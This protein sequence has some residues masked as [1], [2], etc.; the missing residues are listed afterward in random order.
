MTEETSA[1][2]IAP[3]MHVTTPGGGIRL[4]E[5]LPASGSVHVARLN[6]QDMPDEIATFQKF[7]ETLKF[8]E[9][10][11]WN[12]NAF[13]DCLRDLQWLSSDYHVLI[14]ESAESV[15]SADEAARDEFFRS[16]WRA[17]QRWSYTK[18]PEGVTLSK[19]SVV[20]SCAKE[21][22]SSLAKQLGELQTPSSF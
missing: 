7:D 4:D 10:F 6:G 13:Y 22:A 20:L 12:W 15:L 14:I 3:W 19:F 8:P 5:L 2:H 17:G 18:R 1:M 21:S 9:Y 16:L 11:G